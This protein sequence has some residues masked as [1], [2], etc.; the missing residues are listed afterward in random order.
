MIARTA[1]TI[2]LTAYVAVAVYLLVN[3]TVADCETD[4]E[5]AALCA[6]T[7]IECDGGPASLPGVTP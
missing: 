6:A 3:V 4:T 5:C 1:F 7:D 2:L